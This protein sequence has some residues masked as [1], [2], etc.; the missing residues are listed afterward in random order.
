MAASDTRHISAS[1]TLGMPHHHQA[2]AN[3]TCNVHTPLHM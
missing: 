1:L 2:P 3:G